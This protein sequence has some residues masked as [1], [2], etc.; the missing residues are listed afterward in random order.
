MRTNAVSGTNLLQLKMD[1]RIFRNPDL[2][3]RMDGKN[4]ISSKIEQ[5][6]SGKQQESLM[7]RNKIQEMIN[8]KMRSINI[9]SSSKVSLTDG[10]NRR[11]RPSSDGKRSTSPDSICAK[12]SLVNSDNIKGLL[13]KINSKKGCKQKQ[14]NNDENNGNKK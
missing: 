6:L 10:T 4:A 12:K 7:D 2:Y 9:E 5:P 8:T 14:S 3:P 11:N 13:E 1:S